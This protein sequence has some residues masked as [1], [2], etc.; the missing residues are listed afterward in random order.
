[1]SSVK[2]KVFISYHHEDQDEVNEFIK[3]FDEKKEVFITRA[4][5]IE[6]FPDIINSSDTDYIMR[7]IRQLFL[8]DSTVTIVLLGKC[9]YSR[10]YIDWEIQ[11]SLRSGE[12]S[13]PNG[14][15]GI[16]LKSF[17]NSV[18]P[19]R[20]NL[21]LS[22]DGVK[23]CYARVSKYPKSSKELEDLIEDAFKAR[24]SRKNLINN[25]RLRMINNRNCVY[26]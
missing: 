6:R 19:E 17:G 12:F 5:G 26:K 2:H 14:L 18:Y 3:G 22:E 23:D 1:M 16:E 4:I 9:T 13:T 25:P 11:S 21:N 24:D 15:V 10:R 20:L 8:N 7:R